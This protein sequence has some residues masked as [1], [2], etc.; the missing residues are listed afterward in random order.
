MAPALSITFSCILLTPDS[1]A[2]D[3]HHYKPERIGL[4]G[5]QTINQQT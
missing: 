4:S 5:T 3:G 1:E 2:H